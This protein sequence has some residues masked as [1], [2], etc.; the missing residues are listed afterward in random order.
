MTFLREVIVLRHFSAPHGAS[1]RGPHL[2]Y[3]AQAPQACP[4]LGLGL[5]CSEAFGLALAWPWLD[6]GW[7]WLDLA[8]AWL[9]MDLVEYG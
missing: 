3:R 7:L 4:R 8:L 9:W 2:G 1:L 5:A 6:F